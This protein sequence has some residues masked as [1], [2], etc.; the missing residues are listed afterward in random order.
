MTLP[1]AGIK[2]VEVAMWAYVP[3]CG[4]MLSDMG[5]EVIKIE[6]HTGDPSRGLSTGGLG[7][8][9]QG[10]SVQWHIYNR[11]KKSVAMDLAAPGAAEVLYKIIDGA[12]VFLT[13]LLPPARRKMKIDV[14][15]IRS[16]F[17]NIIYAVGSG[18]GAF[19]PDAEKGGYDYISF[20]SRGGVSAAVTPPTEEYPLPMPSGAFGDCTSG[21]MLVAGIAAAI[22]KRERT[23][24]PSVVDGSLLASSLWSMQSK[25]TNVTAAGID[26][27]PKPG[28]RRSFNPLVNVYR[29][30]DGRFLV[31]T[32]LQEQRYWPG[33]CAAMDRPD[34]VDDPRFATA[35]DRQANIEACVDTIDEIFAALTLDEAMT[36][37]HSQPG[38][39]DVVQ[40]P[41]QVHQDRQ[42]VANQLMQ[43]IELDGGRKLKVVSAPIQFDRQPLT[44]RPAPELGADSDAV[45][46]AIG[47][48]EDQIIDLKVAGIVL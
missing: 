11:G 3:S 26:D 21:A 48:D 5:A 9:S 31:L 25:I 43:E 12:D 36:R 34:L 24:E 4:G 19:G 8:G 47:Y 18:Q 40:Q 29:T 7:P 20:W 44:P 30:S 41:G 32:M 28:R 42:V 14:D 22:A 23:G 15:D 45:L 10:V 2:V 16:R 38:Q 46:A 27:L 33:F 35:A 37:L 39:W 6:P 13:S 17:P 1:L